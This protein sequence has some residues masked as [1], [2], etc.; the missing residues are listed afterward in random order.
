MTP[1]SY[2]TNAL[3]VTDSAGS[4]LSISRDYKM[5]ARELV[6]PGGLRCSITMDSMGQL[7]SFVG[8]DN[9]T[10]SFSYLGNSGLIESKENSLGE[11][12][13]YAYDNYGRLAHVI[14]PTGDRLSID[15]E[16]GFGKIIKA[17]SMSTSVCQNT[18]ELKW[19]PAVC[20]DSP[21][22]LSD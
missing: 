10:S 16:N 21:L 4:L 2:V 11:T 17:I 15:A 12:F 7:A 1:Y 9:L 6:T 22:C 20:F 19:S 5:A 13:L 18:I 3:Q 8:V 14:Q